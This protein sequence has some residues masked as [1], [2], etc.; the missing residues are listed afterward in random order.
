MTTP[1]ASFEARARLRMTS[2][3]SL[4]FSQALARVKTEAGATDA[5]LARLRADPRAQ[6]CISITRAQLEGRE[7]SPY[8]EALAGVLEKVLKTP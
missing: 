5:A 3:P 2:D 4:T 8:I 7:T 1:L 6:G